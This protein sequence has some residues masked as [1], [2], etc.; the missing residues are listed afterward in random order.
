[1]PSFL[2]FIDRSSVSLD[3]FPHIVIENLLDDALCGELAAAVP[4][5]GKFSGGRMYP[6]NHKLHLHAHRLLED[7]TL[8]E[9]WRETI[10]NHLTPDAFADMVRLFLPDIA[11]EYPELGRKLGKPSSLKIGVRGRD[12]HCDVALD[13]LL[14]L[15]FPIAGAPCAER[16]PHVKMPKK[17]FESAFCLRQ[18]GDTSAGG[19]LILHRVRG[20]KAP[21]LG[22]RMQ[23]D[24]ALVTPAK[25]IPR[26][27]NTL[28]FWM[29]TPRSVTELT[30]R[31]TSSHPSVYFNILAEFPRKLFRVPGLSS[32]PRFMRKLSSAFRGPRM[33]SEGRNDLQR[34][35][36]VR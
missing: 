5:I 32:G 28:V 20:G 9:R 4:P 16:G 36:P 2:H 21:P 26:K 33:A 27:R 12:E 1:M 23:V 13:A 29:N 7:P 34:T 18:D 14:V 25:V 15:H 8:S 24:R 30:P 11:H 35:A 10:L 22:K 6:D 19:E 3:P 31:A 17:L